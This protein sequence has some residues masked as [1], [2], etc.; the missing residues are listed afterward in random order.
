MNAPKSYDIIDYPV[1]SNKNNSLLK[2]YLTPELFNRL[3]TKK[4]ING[5][6]LKQLINSGV[7][8]QESS[9]GVY[10]G[11]IDSYTTFTELLT[12]VINEYHN[13]ANTS[14]HEKDFSPFDS[15]LKNPDP[16]NKYIL[17]TRIRV[18]RNLAGFPLGPIISKQERNEVETLV[19]KSLANLKGEL[20]GSYYSIQTMKVEEQK[21]LIKEHLLFKEGDRFLDAAGLNRH[22]PEGRGIF[23]NKER[24]FLVWINEED[25]LRIIAMEKGGN[26]ANVF[27]RLSE[28]VASLENSLDFHFDSHL[29]YI[30]SCPTNLGTAMRA[31]VHIKLPKL[32]LNLEKFQQ[33]ASEL[34]IQIRGLHGEHSKSEGGIFDISNK[35]RLGLTE[36]ECIMDLY[37][38]VLELISIEK[39]LYTF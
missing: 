3:K 21:R 36:K 20:S 30:T 37:N 14:S 10:P 19:S 9:I 23:F 24:S 22:W 34:N 8:N 31:S 7:L 17:S 18:G 1:F 11:D 5:F 29:G 15:N 35:R 33:K 39:D 2:K 32:S 27:N 4:T 38:G 13:Y 28:A 12:P 16:E 6:S 25:Q 26:I